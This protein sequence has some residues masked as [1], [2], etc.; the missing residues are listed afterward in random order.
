MTNQ[1]KYSVAVL[2]ST[3]TLSSVISRLARLDPTVYPVAE[4]I[5]FARRID[6]H[7]GRRDGFVPRRVLAEVRRDPAE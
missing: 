5:S 4:S 3:D 7:Y 1:Q 2:L 6:R